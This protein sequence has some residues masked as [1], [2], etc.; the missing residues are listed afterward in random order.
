MA[1]GGILTVALAIK[2]VC[3]IAQRKPKSM[4]DRDIS[5]RKITDFR[6]SMGQFAI[7]TQNP[8]AGTCIQVRHGK[9]GD[10]GCAGAIEWQDAY[11]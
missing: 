2:R 11:L 6:K 8:T 5:E 4:A 9:L 3:E 10:T 1:A 7:A